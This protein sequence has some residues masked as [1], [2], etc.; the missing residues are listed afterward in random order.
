MSQNRIKELLDNDSLLL[1]I[2]NRK[3]HLPTSTT[4]VYNNT[5]I[6]N[7]TD[8]YTSNKLGNLISGVVKM[9]RQVVLTKGEDGFLIVECPSLPGCYSQ[10][11]DEKEAINNI[12]E[13]IEL[14]LEV[15]EE[16]NINLDDLAKVVEV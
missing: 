11:K 15:A 1:D 9:K 4:I 3:E 12:K 10:G 14:Y 13:A 6:V 5:Y 8:P 7:N 16:D 2:E